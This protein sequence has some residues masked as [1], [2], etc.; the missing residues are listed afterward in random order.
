[1][2]K[3]LI[4]S[5]ILSVALGIA[6]TAGCARD[7]KDDEYRS[8][9]LS[10]LPFVYKMTVQQGNLITEEM[11]D[12][13]QFGMTKSQ[14]RYLLGTPLL[15][16]MFHTNRWDYTYTIERGHEPMV[17]KRLTVYFQ[18]DALSR[19]DGAMQPNPERALA[20]QDE[21][22][23]VIKV[24]DWRDNRGLINRTLTTIGLE[25]QD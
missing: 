21:P 15:A 22:E 6:T 13:L 18:D 25:P 19:I 16:D 2:R 8:S 1:M 20:A 3:L 14:V 9:V 7:K 17:I 4:L 12:Q 5:V 11:V 10:D 24:P 23:V